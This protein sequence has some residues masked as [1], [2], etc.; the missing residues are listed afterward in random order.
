MAKTNYESGLKGSL[1]QWY[2]RG[3]VNSGCDHHVQ[4]GQHAPYQGPNSN[5]PQDNSGLLHSHARFC[6]RGCRIIRVTDINRHLVSKVFYGVH[7]WNF[8]WQSITSMSGCFYRKSPVARLC[9]AEHYFGPG[10][11]CSGRSLL[12]R[13]ETLLQHTFVHSLV[14]GVVQHSP[15]DDRRTDIAEL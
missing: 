2:H 9:E 10:Q 5:R 14:H 15:Y 11:S 3:L 8:R 13:R 4:S 7:I 12:P 1:D 6:Y